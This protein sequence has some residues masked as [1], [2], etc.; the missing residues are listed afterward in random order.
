MGT[1]GPATRLRLRARRLHELARTIESTP[2]M[3]LERHAG[4]DAWRGHR[5]S[6]CRT[7]L[8]SNQHQVHAAVEELRWSAHQLEQQADQLEA[9]A[10][11]SNI[12]G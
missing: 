9:A 1:T 4:D 3:S 7:L 6:L 11:F 5:P 8:M 2:A 12:A 10:R